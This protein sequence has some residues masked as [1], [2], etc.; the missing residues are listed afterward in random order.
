MEVVTELYTRNLMVLIIFME[1]S[2]KLK[3]LL[4]ALLWHLCRQV[5]TVML[6]K[7]QSNINAHCHLFDGEHKNAEVWLQLPTVFGISLT[8]WGVK[9]M[10]TLAFPSISSKGCSC[11]TPF[12]GEW[13][14][15][16]GE[17]CLGLGSFKRRCGSPS[18][19]T[20]SSLK[21]LIWRNI[22]KNSDDILGWLRQNTW[23]TSAK[24]TVK[25][26]QLACYWFVALF[27]Q[28]SLWSCKVLAL[29]SY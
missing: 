23:K 25:R 10:N 28:Y 27:K 17:V 13:E 15:G 4:G 12:L 26:Q 22:W 24:K 16:E 11:R 9:L 20:G 3:D 6:S 1:I 19:S 7:S 21:S 8:C 5:T 14:K 29:T 18:V 2:R